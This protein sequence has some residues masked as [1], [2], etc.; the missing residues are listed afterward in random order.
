MSLLKDV[1]W[2]YEGAH[3]RRHTQ[4]LCIYTVHTHI[5]NYCVH[6]HTRYIYAHFQA[7]AMHS[8]HALEYC[9]HAW[10]IDTHPQT[11]CTHS[12]HTFRHYVHEGIQTNTQGLCTCT[13]HTHLHIMYRWYTYI[14]SS[15]A[16]TCYAH[17]IMCTHIVHMQKHC[18][19]TKVWYTH[20]YTHRC[21][22]HHHHHLHHWQKKPLPG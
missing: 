13:E 22:R 14:H 10:Y 1:S 17:S 9:A 6:V 21:C 15:T 16:H 11:L 19:H 4:A 3:I 2:H 12:T 8:T 5:L 20:T 7:W 18:A